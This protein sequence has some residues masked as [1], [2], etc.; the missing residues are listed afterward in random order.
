M[1]EA[2]VSIFRRRRAGLS[3][4][5]GVASRERKTE[6]TGGAFVLAPR[7][8]SRNHC[9]VCGED[10]SAGRRCFLAHGRA[11][12]EVVAHCDGYVGRGTMLA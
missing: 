10:D 9:R 3:T 8:L 2:S 5:H 12:D 11:L 1:C 7:G 4:A 6:R